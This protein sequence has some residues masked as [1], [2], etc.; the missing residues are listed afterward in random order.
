MGSI[1]SL[2]FALPSTMEE[3]NWVDTAATATKLSF[4]HLRHLGLPVR[5]FERSLAFYAAYFEFDPATA[6][7][8]S[9]GTLI[10]RNADRFDLA[11]HPGTEAAASSTF[12]HFGFA[13][14]DA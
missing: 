8:Y 11:L 13:L 4:V 6:Q 14:A 7:T 1:V 9:D 2:H 5:D 12:L 3:H 10:V